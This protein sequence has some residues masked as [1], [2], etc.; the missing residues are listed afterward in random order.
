MFFYC[1][2]SVFYVCQ[3]ST[4]LHDPWVGTGT[5]GYGEAVSAGQDLQEQA[6][7]NEINRKLRLQNVKK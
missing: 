4:N 7:V 1:F 3:T 5:P 2:L 6:P